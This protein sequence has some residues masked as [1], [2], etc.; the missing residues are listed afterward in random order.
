MIIYIWLYIYDY[1]LIYIYV[2]FI[3]IYNMYVMYVM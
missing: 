2:G 3:I 1:M